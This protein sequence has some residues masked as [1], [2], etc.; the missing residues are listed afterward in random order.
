LGELPLPRPPQL[1]DQARQ[2]LRVRRYALRTEDCYVQWIL[3]F[4]LY[5]CI[6]TSGTR[7]TWGRQRSNSSGRLA[8]EGRVSASTQKQALGALLFLYAQVL[9][10]DKLGNDHDLYPRRAERRGR[11]HQPAGPAGRRDAGSD[12]GGSRHVAPGTGPRLNAA[13]ATA[14]L[15]AAPL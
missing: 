9:E 1:L 6:T 3:R 4:I 14:L 13:V 12:S 11:T 5:H 10:I 7:A 15:L 8:V 2:L